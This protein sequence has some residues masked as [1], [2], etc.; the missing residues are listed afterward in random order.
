[1]IIT[2]LVAKVALNS[3]NL[4]S[5]RKNPSEV[6]SLVYNSIKGSAPYIHFYWPS[7]YKLEIIDEFERG[8][9][10]I[11]YGR[12]VQFEDY[13]EFDDIDEYKSKYLYNYERDDI[14]FMYDKASQ[15]IFFEEKSD[16]IKEIFMDQ[17]E[18]I[19]NRQNFHVAVSVNPILNK[20]KIKQTLKSFNKITTAYFEVIPDNP[21]NRLN[22]KIDKLLE[23]MNATAGR[24][25]VSNEDGLNNGDEMDSIVGDV[26]EGKKRRVVC[27]GSDDLG[28][29]KI[30]DSADDS[31]LKRVTTEID[32]NE[33]GRKG[34][35]WQAI[36]ETL[37]L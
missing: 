25:E 15:Y 37:N 10:S 20:E 30:F 19:I 1:M 21:S 2:I 3:E 33:E 34:G 8:A 16:F 4:F 24:I 9:T 26:A 32:S 7:H 31:N 14:Y 17:L 27:K 18:Y 11:L 35:L 6:K 22:D 5:L 12:M 13:N 23:T 36:L 28:N 29:L